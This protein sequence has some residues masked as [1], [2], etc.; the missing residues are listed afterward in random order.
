MMEIDCRL[1]GEDFETK[2][3]DS[4][5]WEGNEF[6]QWGTMKAVAQLRKIRGGKGEKWEIRGKWRTIEIWG[7]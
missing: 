7:K 1:L 6:I 4:L 2:W 3:V 5:Q